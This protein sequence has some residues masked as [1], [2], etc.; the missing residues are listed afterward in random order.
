MKAE[1]RK[2]LE[3]NAL[4]QQLTKA[5]EGLKQGPSR[6]TVV[7]ISVIVG[8]ILV[9]GLFRYFW[10]SSRATDSKRWGELDEIVFPEQLDGLL[11]DKTL[12]GTPQGRMAQFMEARLN[13]AQGLR[14]QGSNH[15]TAVERLRKARDAYE[16]LAR[17]SGRVPLL[18]QEALWGAAKANEALGDYP[19][20][21]ELYERLQKEYSASALGKDAEK[22][23]ERLRNEANEKDL[24]QLKKLFGDKES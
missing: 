3:S 2:E 13:L 11:K 16:E 18:H 22:Q 8:V 1:H 14:G 24:N 15:S 23:I 10:T 21:V 6:S 20:A 12:A 19:R 5:Y 17:Q 9:V 7:W 4:A